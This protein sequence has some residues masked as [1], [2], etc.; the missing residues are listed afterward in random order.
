M[1]LSRAARIILVGAPGVGKGTQANRLLQRFSQLST[2]SS[3]DL[4][5]DNV[6]NQTPLGIK[7]EAAMKSGS[8]VPDAM[9]LRLIL[10]ELK[11]RG[12]LYPA[13]TP[14][15]F[16]LASSG[17]ATQDET[18]ADADIFVNPSLASSQ[19]PLLASESP[20]ASFILDGFPR[21][22][23]QAMA[24]DAIIPINLVVS[25]KTPS[26]VI[27]D[28]IRHRWVHQPSGRVYNTTFNLPKVPGRDDVTGELLTKRDDDSEEVW[29]ERL[30]K[31]DETSEPLLRHYKAKGVL[32]EV[33]GNSSDEITPVLLKEFEK[34]F[35]L[36]N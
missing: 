12:W 9:I 28:R 18:S 6:R 2:I 14:Q 13:S 5:R 1:K 10:N 22:A 16:T 26:S 25:L 35:A 20:S 19:I 23:T 31:F 3:G 17:L 27:L 34:R 24:L 8:L 7:A 29:M 15:P 36:L 30:R 4:L 21:T 33:E 11:S 32:W